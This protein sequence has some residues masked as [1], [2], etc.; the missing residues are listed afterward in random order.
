MKTMEQNQYNYERLVK[1]FLSYK[2]IFFQRTE[3]TILN[4]YIKEIIHFNKYLNIIGLGQ[5]CL[6]LSSR[7]YKIYP[8]KK[9]LSHDQIDVE[10]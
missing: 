9:N 7:K 8:K 5:K 1:F 2:K 3:N 6:K 4:Y 10:Y